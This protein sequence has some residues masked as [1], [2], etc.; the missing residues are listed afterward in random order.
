MDSAAPDDADTRDWQVICLCAQWCG[1]C[2]EWRGIFAQA[3]ATHPD[4]RFAW[5]DVEDEADAMG[6]VDVETFP[7]LL[8]AHGQRARFLGPVQPTAG[9][10]TRML[11]GLQSGSDGASGLAEAD[12]LLSRLDA[13]VLHKL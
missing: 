2:R 8:I 11:M 1:V 3:A 12:A 10:V 6:D 9:H 5:V 13:A 7:T 4:V